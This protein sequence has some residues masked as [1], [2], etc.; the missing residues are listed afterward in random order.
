MIASQRPPMVYH[1]RARRVMGR[2]R[3]RHRTV[4]AGRATA[5]EHP[6]GIRITTCMGRGPFQGPARPRGSLRSPV[7][8]QDGGR[9]GAWQACRAMPCRSAA[10]GPS[11][12]FATASPVR[13][14][15][16]SRPPSVG[17]TGCPADRTDRGAIRGTP[18]CARFAGRESGSRARPVSTPGRGGSWQR[19][20][21]LLDRESTSI[22]ER[23]RGVSPRGRP[24][25]RRRI[26]PRKGA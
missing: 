6:Q 1:R 3:G 11:G 25:A 18:A 13:G 7:S 14:Q 23:R 24:P 26:P 10:V 8:G 4:S 9:A 5:A 2:R 22:H 15:G 17:H 16:V 12:M 20:E 21:H 19:P